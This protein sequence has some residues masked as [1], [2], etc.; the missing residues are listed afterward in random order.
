MESDLLSTP[1]R[2]AA[3]TDAMCHKR[4]CSL[5]R[6]DQDSLPNGDEFLGE[7]KYPGVRAIADCD[8]GLASSSFSLFS[9]VFLH[10]HDCGNVALPE[11]LRAAGYDLREDG[12][13]Q[14]ILAAA[15][16]ESFIRRV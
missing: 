12:E 9:L 8:G 11:E 6:S 5:S 15:I 3:I 2:C 7:I 16:V 1:D 14:R 4:N 10:L 13:G